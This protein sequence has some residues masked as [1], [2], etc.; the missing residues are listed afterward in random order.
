[1]I[2]LGSTVPTRDLILRL[3]LA[4]G[5]VRAGDDVVCPALT[6]V[7]TANAIRYTGAR[8]VFADVVSLD[9][10]NVGRET[11]EAIATPATKA[12]I[13]VHYGGYPCDMAAICAWA[14]DRR[15]FVI[16]DVAHAPGAHIGGRAMGSWGDFGCFSFF[17][18]KN[19]TIGEG[20]M[21]TTNR[22]DVIVRLRRLRSHGMTTVTLD[23]HKGH[24]Y[25]Y[26]V[27]E[28]GFNYR[29]SELNAALGLVQLA[30]LGPRNAQRRQL[31]GHYRTR[32][33]AIPRLSVPFQRARGEP[34]YHLT[35]VLLPQCA[36][37]SRVIDRLRA[38]GIQTGIHYRPVDTFTAYQE[39]RLGSSPQLSFT[40]DIGDR[41]LTL[42]LYPSLG[43][44]EV[45]YVCEHLTQTLRAA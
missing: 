7:A 44:K 5:D 26:D 33:S 2:K 1:M 4:A 11:I 25:S 10:W 16:E 14:R 34:A 30:D 45:N 23:R 8:P 9:E 24:A 31:V 20:G 32:L 40:H 38:A 37:R 17:S 29:M 21:V 18:N 43:E 13:V 36:D 15:I 3:A 6:F 41:Q 19:L 12:V 42:P 22:D 39:A 28:L 35:P 27:T